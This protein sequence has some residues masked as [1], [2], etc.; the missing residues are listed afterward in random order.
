MRDSRFLMDYVIVRLA[1]QNKM[2]L[3]VDVVRVCMELERMFPG[4]TIET[5]FKEAQRFFGMWYRNFEQY[6]GH[7]YVLEGVSNEFETAMFETSY[8]YVEATIFNS[9]QIGKCTMRHMM[10]EHIDGYI[11]GTAKFPSK[12]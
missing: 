12:Q 4:V 1:K 2:F 9:V 10:N 5:S 11:T 3:I 8:V 7:V 6:Q